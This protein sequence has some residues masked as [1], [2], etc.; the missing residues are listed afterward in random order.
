MS[1]CKIVLYPTTGR[2]LPAPKLVYGQNETSSLVPRDG[3][4][5]MKNYKFI[6]AKSMYHSYDF[7]K[8]FFYLLGT[9]PYTLFFNFNYQN[10][11]L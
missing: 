3:V 8:I 10:Y 5:N 4:W 6:D 9:V 2:V 7:S 1:Y 11:I